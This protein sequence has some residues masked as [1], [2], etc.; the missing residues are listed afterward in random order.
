MSILLAYC[1]CIA[2]HKLLAVLTE[3][4]D[5]FLVVQPTVK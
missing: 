1:D 2:N 4:C 5:V 3:L